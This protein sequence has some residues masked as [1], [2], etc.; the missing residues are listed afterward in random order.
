MWSLQLAIPHF[1][2]VGVMG[3]IVSMRP[4]MLMWGYSAFFGFW[5]YGS[6]AWESAYSFLVSY[7]VFVCTEF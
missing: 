1:V 7:G 6:Y 2:L 5:S 4:Y 3:F